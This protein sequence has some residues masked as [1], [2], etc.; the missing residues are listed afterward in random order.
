MNAKKAEK[1]SKALSD[2]HRLKIVNQVKKQGPELACCHLE[3]VLDLSQ[4]SVCHH[5]KLLT[6][7]E[8]LISRKEGKYVKYQINN[9]LLEEYIAFLQQLKAE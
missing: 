1:I 6:D 3:N 2:Q 4:P 9:R 5:L 7:A 8:I